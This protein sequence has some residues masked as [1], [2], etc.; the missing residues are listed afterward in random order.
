MKKRKLIA[1]I[2][3]AG[4][5]TVALASCKKDPTYTIELE[6]IQAGTN[7][8]SDDKITVKSV[9]ELITKLAEITPVKDGYTFKGWFIDA[10]CK[11]EFT[12]D[13][14]ITDIKDEKDG[15]TDG[16]L[17]LYAKWTKNEYTITFDYKGNASVAGSG[18]ASD[19]AEY[20]TTVAANLPTTPGK[21]ANGAEMTFVGWKNKEDNQMWN[22]TD[23]KVTKNV[24][25]EAVWDIATIATAQDFVQYI[26]SKSTKNAEITADIDMTGVTVNRTKETLAADEATAGLLNSNQTDYIGELKH[27][28]FGLDHT[29]SNLNITT[30]LKYGGIWG[31]VTA[32]GIS[33]LT[34]KDCSITSSVTEST[35]FLGGSL[36]GDFDLTDVVFDGID[37][38][39]SA[40]N[41]KYAAVIFSRSEGNLSASG[42]VVKGATGE[43]SDYSGLFIGQIRNAGTYDFT[44]CMVD[45]QIDVVHKADN[46]TVGGQG[47]GLFIGQLNSGLAATVTFDGCVASGSIKALKNVGTLI[48]DQKSETA[49]VTVRNCIVTDFVGDTTD[50]GSDKVDVFIGQDKNNATYENSH[51]RKYGIS[52]TTGKNGAQ[53]P[54]KGIASTIETFKTGVLSSNFEITVDETT[55]NIQVTLKD[56]GSK[57]TDTDKVSIEGKHDPIE[58]NVTQKPTIK[59]DGDNKVSFNSDDSIFIGAPTLA[60]Y[61]AAVAGKAGNAVQL[62]FTKPEDVANL[63]GFDVLSGDLENVEM[64]AN[65]FT[66]YVFITEEEFAAYLE[67]KNADNNAAMTK[68]ATIRWYL[69]NETVAKEVVYTMKIWTGKTELP[70]DTTVAPEI[71]VIEKDGITAQV[72]T[73]D[74]K[75]INV[76]AGTIAWN[77]ETSSNT[78]Q[79]K[80]LKPTWANGNPSVKGGKFVLDESG[81]FITVTLDAGKG[82]NKFSI[83]WS[84]VVDPIEFVVNVADTVTLEARPQTGEK[85]NISLTG[86]EILA[87]AKTTNDGVEIDKKAAIPVGKYG[88]FYLGDTITRGNSNTDC[89]ELVPTKKDGSKIPGYVKFYANGAGVLKIKVASTGGSNTSKGALYDN[90]GNVVEGSAIVISGSTFTEFTINI[91]AAGDYNIMSDITFS[92]RGIRIS[93]ISFIQA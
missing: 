75:K 76:T 90:A 13:S 58:T 67:A 7:I 69:N 39:S 57:Q 62:Q 52:L 12:K 86:T 15:E 16:V 85:Q 31:K 1:S 66:A 26:N 30:D 11:T 35:A 73:T 68:T 80:V 59:Y 9:D 70:K 63:D 83:T 24:Q 78:Y 55:K 77:T 27:K 40:D 21:T 43:F 71:Q 5:A 92:E 50:T 87:Q 23:N 72:D 84:N 14:A 46:T 44:D 53:Y 42:V 36:K 2:A 8:D 60:Y 56:T 17:T 18:K 10:A 29:I 41:S 91:T 32:G 38:S 25:L 61:Q 20:N 28:V 48:G 64:T 49:T 93:E 34:F 51:Y 54:I 37:V 22:F 81:D 89:I 82:D 74:A 33:D 88:E 4:I 65:G 3:V 79:V 6:P 45:A 19:S 47:V